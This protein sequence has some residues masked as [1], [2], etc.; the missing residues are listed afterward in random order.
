MA[1]GFAAGNV[2][3]ELVDPTEAPT[4]KFVFPQ[5]SAIPGEVV[6]DVLWLLRAL[7]SEII[8]KFARQTPAAG[9]SD[10]ADLQCHPLLS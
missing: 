3:L 5:D 6:V 10:L 9:V 4:V 8:E 2:E 1:I 7:V